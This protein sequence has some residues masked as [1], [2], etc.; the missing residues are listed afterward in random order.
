MGVQSSIPGLCLRPEG[1]AD[2]LGCAL[3]CWSVVLEGFELPQIAQQ[4]PLPVPSS[5]PAYGMMAP[6]D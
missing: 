1:R 6:G 4:A 5:Q 2:I 3:A